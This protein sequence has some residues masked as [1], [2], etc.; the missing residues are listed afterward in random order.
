MQQLVENI[1]FI[2][3]IFNQLMQKFQG[4]ATVRAAAA[5]SLLCLTFYCEQQL[6]WKYQ[7]SCRTS[8]TTTGCNPGVRGQPAPADCCPPHIHVG[9]SCT[10]PLLRST[11]QSSVS[12]AHIRQGEQ[13]RNFWIYAGL[14]VPSQRFWA[15]A[16]GRS[17]QQVAAHTNGQRAIPPG[18]NVV[19]ETQFMHLSYFQPYFPGSDVTFRN[20]FNS[21]YSVEANNNYNLWLCITEVPT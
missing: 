15:N 13:S 9:L 10:D 19:P 1:T 21:Y 2:S 20:C 12:A 4:G 7:P 3:R 18:Q 6:E 16:G 17:P 14:H 5:P 11:Y 8:H